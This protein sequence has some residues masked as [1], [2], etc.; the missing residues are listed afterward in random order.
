MLVAAKFYTNM[1]SACRKKARRKKKK[2]KNSDGKVSC[3]AYG[4]CEATQVPWVNTHSQVPYLIFK[5]VRI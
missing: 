3:S 5:K 1:Q 2:K 4:L